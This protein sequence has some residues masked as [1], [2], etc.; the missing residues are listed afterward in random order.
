MY[1]N[2]LRLER[3]KDYY[4][5]AVRQEGIQEWLYRRKCIVIHTCT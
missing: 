5:H 2:K 1:G 4:I 3:E